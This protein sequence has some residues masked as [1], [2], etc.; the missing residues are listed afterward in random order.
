MGSA[1]ITAAPLSTYNID[2]AAHHTAPG[3]LTESFKDESYRV[4]ADG[5]AYDSTAS[6]KNETAL[7]VSCGKLIYPSGTMFGDSGYDTGITRYYY[8]KFTGAAGTKFGGTIKLN[9]LT[10]AKFNTLN[11]AKISVDNGATWLNLKADRGG[12]DPTGI[13]TGFANNTVTFNMPG[14][15]SY[16]G[17]TGFILKLGWDASDNITI[18]N[19]TVTM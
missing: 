8:R 3:T 5:T 10:E 2:V 19:I 4:N 11:E 14:E 6:I 1:D 13:K 9:S 16:E 17:S 7:M 18:T 15:T 12:D